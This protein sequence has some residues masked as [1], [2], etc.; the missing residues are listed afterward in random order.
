MIFDAQRTIRNLVVGVRRPSPARTAAAAGDAYAE[1]RRQLLAANTTVFR[2]EMVNLV[3]SLASLAAGVMAAE[4]VYNNRNYGDQILGQSASAHALKLAT[5]LLTAAML[6]VQAFIFRFELSVQ[7]LQGHIPADLAFWHTRLFRYYVGE[8]LVMAVHMPVGCYGLWSTVNIGGVP[9]TYD[10][11]SL[12]SC[13]MFVRL[14]PLIM[15]CINQLSDFRSESAMHL[16]PCVGDV[17]MDSELAVRY[18]LKRF[19]LTFTSLMYMLTVFVLGYWLRVVERILCISPEAISLAMCLGVTKDTDNM[20]NSLWAILITSLTVG[21]GDIFPFTHFGRLVCIIAALTGICIIALLVN[22]VSSYA[23]MNE[24][25]ERACDLL[26]LKKRNGKKAL[27]AGRLR[28]AFVL[29][30]VHVLRE[31]RGLAVAGGGGAAATSAAGSAAGGSKVRRARRLL[32]LRLAQW[33]E[34][35]RTWSE[36]KWRR[37]PMYATRDDIRA[38]RVRKAALLWC[39]SLRASALCA[40]ILPGSLCASSPTV[41]P[42]L[43]H[44]RPPPP[45][46]THTPPLCRI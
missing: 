8:A 33:K 7:R 15:V 39:L 43:R 20:Y 28:G 17:H 23:K 11:D 46:H 27:V 1:R 24:A 9:I 22:A 5:T 16:A 4:T 21:Y 30:C 31:R 36:A 29:L 3:L 38:L 18:L 32:S 42:S 12:L 26:E 40:A 13:L 35:L 45:P 25:E 2:L 44:P 41:S 19:S 37:D 6:L 14:K 34:H 10:W